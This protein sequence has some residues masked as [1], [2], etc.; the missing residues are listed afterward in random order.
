[1]PSLQRGAARIIGI[2]SVSG[3]VIRADHLHRLFGFQIIERQIDGAA[4]IVPRSFCGIGYENFLV[5]RRRVPEDFG[6]VPGA[7]SIMNEQSVP[8]RLQLAMGANDRFSS[9]ALHKRAGFGIEDGAEEIVGRR[10]ADFKSDGRI[11]FS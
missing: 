3:L 8:E 10:I 5:V 7:V 9:R 4:A 2:S 11:E 6:Y 1:M